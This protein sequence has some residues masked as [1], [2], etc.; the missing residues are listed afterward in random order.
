[1]RTRLMILAG[2]RAGDRGLISGAAVGVGTAMV[3]VPAVCGAYTVAGVRQP[4][5]HDRVKALAPDGRGTS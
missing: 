1:M 2:I 5:L 3:E 4:G